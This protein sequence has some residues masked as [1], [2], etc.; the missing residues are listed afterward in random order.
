[1]SIDAVMDDDAREMVM[2]NYPISIY[3]VAVDRCI[4]ASLAI[5]V[6]VMREKR[7]KGHTRV[8]VNI[9]FSSHFNY[10]CFESMMSINKK[11]K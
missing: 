2:I 8:K 7:N 11:P 1:M 5:P 10:G 4:R 3:Y 9:D 6:H